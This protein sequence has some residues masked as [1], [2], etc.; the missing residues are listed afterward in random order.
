MKYYPTC[1][2]I[3]G[4]DCSGGAGIQADLKTMSA[5]GVYGMSVITA[6]TAQ[7]TCGVQSIYPIPSSMVAA[8]IDA[9]LSDVGADAIK[10][11]MLHN[12]ACVEVV[13]QALDRYKPLSLVLDPIMISTSG[14]RLIEEECIDLIYREL[15]PR[16]TLVTPNTDEATFL[17]RIPITDLTSMQAAGEALLQNGCNAVLMKGGHLKGETMTDI[18]FRKNHAP[19]TLTSPYIQTKNMHGTGCTLSSAIASFL[20]LGYSLTEAFDRSK[21]Y[22]SAAIEAGA[23]VRVGEGSGPVNH[24]FAPQPLLPVER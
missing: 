2:T 24:Q 11:G 6:I 9:V 13:I 20:A 16:A 22:I 23:E 17:T 4:S 19:I 15:F 21:H 14:H 8:Q 12:S 1:L 10:L 18:L 3:A 7:N 5:L